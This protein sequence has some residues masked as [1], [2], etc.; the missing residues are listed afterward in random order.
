MISI[1]AILLLLF[2]LFL[3]F[4]ATNDSTISGIVKHADVTLWDYTS[5]WDAVYGMEEGSLTSYVYEVQGGNLTRVDLNSGSVLCENPEIHYITLIAVSSPSLVLPLRAGNL[6]QLDMYISSSGVDNASNTF[7]DLSSFDLSYG[8]FSNVPSV[9]LPNGYQEGYLQ[10]SLG[11]FVFVEPLCNHCTNWKGDPSDYEMILPR[12]DSFSVNY[13]LWLD[14]VY[15]CKPVTYSGGS[16]TYY[17][18]LPAVSGGAGSGLECTGG[19]LEEGFYDVNCSVF[20]KEPFL[21]NSL[22]EACLAEEFEP[23]RYE[24]I[25]RSCGGYSNLTLI[26]HNPNNYTLLGFLDEEPFNS[27]AEIS[28]L[29]FV[30]SENLFKF[31]FVNR[32]STGVINLAVLPSLSEKPRI[33]KCSVYLLDLNASIDDGLKLAFYMYNPNDDICSGSALVKWKVL[34]Y[35]DT[36][37]KG[38]I[39]IPLELSPGTS[40]VYEYSVPIWD[41]GL[42]GMLAEVDLMVYGNNLERYFDKFSLEIAHKH[43]IYS[44]MWESDGKLYV[45]NLYYGNSP[46]Y[47]HIQ[48]YDDSK[49]YL[50]DVYFRAPQISYSSDELPVYL[51]YYELP[52]STSTLFDPI[53]PGIYS[54]KISS[55]LGMFER[56]VII[57]KSVGK[58]THGLVIVVLIGALALILWRISVRLPDL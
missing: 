9:S 8:Q 3:V 55:D 4:G 35:S 14:V 2:S 54:Y 30:S 15:E 34:D 39:H 46:M 56:D 16:G 7:V 38:T 26:L 36:L 50:D 28:G 48:V 25:Y 44:K 11:N 58:Y 31:F 18:S 42:P 47:E 51:N 57:N 13:T 5:H 33:S 24:W 27:T 43:D 52:T 37:R 6:T 53:S 32:K 22:Y 10:D 19:V 1:R 21:N 20:L 49:V 40:G 29:N 41:C 23:V 12:N 45:C 17:G